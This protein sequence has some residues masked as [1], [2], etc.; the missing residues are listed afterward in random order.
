MLGGNKESPVEH[1]EVSNFFLQANN[2]FDLIKSEKESSEADI[3]ETLTK[4]SNQSNY[5]YN[6]IVQYYFE[7]HVEK[8]K[9]NKVKL[10]DLNN[11]MND[12]ASN[13]FSNKSTT[14]LVKFK[15]IKK[16]ILDNFISDIDEY[17]KI[18]FTEYGTLTVIPFPKVDVHVNNINSAKFY[19]DF[20]IILR[21]KDSVLWLEVPSFISM[22]FHSIKRAIKDRFPDITSEELFETIYNTSILLGDY[23]I[24]SEEVPYELVVPIKDG[25]GYGNVDKKS[26]NFV[27]YKYFRKVYSTEKEISGVTDFIYSP[28]VITTCIDRSIMNYKQVALSNKLKDTFTYNLENFISNYSQLHKDFTNKFTAIKG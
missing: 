13:L 3:F 21:G 22:T 23:I 24:N 1:L 9:S 26:V 6:Q 27:V 19:Y 15:D 8:I 14:E 11:R 7:D 2:L 17:D 20:I 12:F 18:D 16:N 5:T 25:L 28:M 4:L 10:S